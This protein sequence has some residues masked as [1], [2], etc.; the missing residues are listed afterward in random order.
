MHTW[1]PPPLILEPSD[2]L[3]MRWNLIGAMATSTGCGTSLQTCICCCIAATLLNTVSARRALLSMLSSHALPS[4]A[5]ISAYRLVLRAGSLGLQLA[6]PSPSGLLAWMDVTASH[7]LVS[8]KAHVGCVHTGIISVDKL[9]CVRQSY[10]GAR[11]ACNT[12]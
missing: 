2:T 11:C 6:D 10:C 8:G 9:S 4:S 7:R 5:M 12:M 3:A 1:H